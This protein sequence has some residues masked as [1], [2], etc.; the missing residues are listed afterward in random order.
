MVI[1]PRLVFLGVYFLDGMEKSPVP[2]VLGRAGLGMLKSVADTA[3]LITQEG[4]LMQLKVLHSKQVRLSL[5]FIF[6][7]QVDCYYSC[8][9]CSYLLVT[10]PTE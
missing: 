2:P 4:E 6:K 8:C 1:V 3:P 10:G 5:V 9:W 7:N